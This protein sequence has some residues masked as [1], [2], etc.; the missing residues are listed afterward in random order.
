ILVAAVIIHY[1]SQL[2]IEDS[3]VRSFLVFTPVACAG[4]FTLFVLVNRYRG[5]VNMAK[6]LHEQSQQH[7]DRMN[8]FVA[9]ADNYFFP[10]D[11]T[12]TPLNWYRGFSFFHNQQTDSALVYF[13][14]AELQ[15]PYHIQVLN[16]LGACYENKGDHIRAMQYFDRVLQITPFYEETMLNKIVSTYNMG[17][18]QEAYGL[19]HARTYQWT[20]FYLSCRR[21]IIGSV[22]SEVVGNGNNKAVSEKLSNDPWISAIEEKSNGSLSKLKIVIAEEFQK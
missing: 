22:V 4:I 1:R 3:N 11:L 19:L 21:A 12:T 8:K 7:F 10:L 6:A 20:Q 14:K 2:K 17:K 15:S 5:E 13:H 9:E 18:V 16:D